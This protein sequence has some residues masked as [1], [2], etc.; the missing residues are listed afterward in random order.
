MRRGELAQRG[1][2]ECGPRECGPHAAQVQ[3]AAWALAWPPCA[4]IALCQ[5]S[6]SV[7]SLLFPPHRYAL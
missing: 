5:N 7:L 1:P 6:P 3:R 2:R 4:C